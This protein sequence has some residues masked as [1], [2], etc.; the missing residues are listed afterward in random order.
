MKF[1]RKNLHQ[2]L[3]KM[4]KFKAMIKGILPFNLMFARNSLQPGV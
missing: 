3:I 2:L 1:L 4:A